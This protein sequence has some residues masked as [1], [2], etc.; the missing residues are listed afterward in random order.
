M[1]TIHSLLWYTQNLWDNRSE[2]TRYRIENESYYNIVTFLSLVEGIGN[3]KF[4]FVHFSACMGGMLQGCGPH[5]DLDSTRT[6]VLLL[7]C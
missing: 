4:S 1:I 5:R 3:I 7:Y 6:C 2:I